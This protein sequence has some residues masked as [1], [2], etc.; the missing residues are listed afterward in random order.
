MNSVY[1]E[2]FKVNLCLSFLDFFVK[3]EFLFDN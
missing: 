1:V 3:I 2:F